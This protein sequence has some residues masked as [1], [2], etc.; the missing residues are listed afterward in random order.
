MGSITIVVGS[1]ILAQ[2]KLAGP[3]IHHL[4][5]IWH[6]KWS[7]LVLIPVLVKFIPFQRVTGGHTAG[8]SQ[9]SRDLGELIK[10]TEMVGDKQIQDN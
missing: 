5:A 9:L 4:F 8:V 1:E 10:N 3:K 6:S 7:K 2:P